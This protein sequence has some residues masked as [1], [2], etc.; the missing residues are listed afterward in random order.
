MIVHRFSGNTRWLLVRRLPAKGKMSRT[1][2]ACAIPALLTSMGGQRAYAWQ[3]RGR[4]LGPD[5]LTVLDETP[6]KSM[7]ILP[8]A[9]GQVWGIESLVAVMAQTT[10]L[11]RG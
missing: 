2:Y 6:L 10:A 9:S 5:A 11:F 8:V 1:E 3:Q 4:V 7:G